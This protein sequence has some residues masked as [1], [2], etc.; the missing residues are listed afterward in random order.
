MGVTSWFRGLFGQKRQGTG[1]E[2]SRWSSAPVRRGTAQLIF[3][4]KELPWLNTIVDT[5]SDGVADLQWKVYRPVSSGGALC[6]DFSLRFGNSKQRRE[7]LKA[8]LDAGEAV[9]VNNH[10]LLRLISDPNDY[11][12][13]RQV[14]KLVQT[15]LDLV[16]EAFLVLDLQGKLPVGYWPLPPHAVTLLPD[17]TLPPADQ[18][19]TVTFG[20]AS[21][22]VPA[23]QIVHLRHPDPDDPMGRGVGKGFT[24]GDELDTD[25]Y[26]AQFM[27]NFFFNNAMPAGV[28]SIEGAPP[29]FSTT[30]QAQEFRESL[31]REYG[32]SK[33]AGKVMLTG[34][35]VSV[36]RLDTDF[37]KMDLNSLRKGLRDFTRMNW[38]IPPEIVGDLTSSSKTAAWAAHDNLAKQAIVPRGEFLRSEFQMR[39][40]PFFG[41]E[42]DIIDYGSPCPEDQEFELRVMGTFPSSFT[43]NEARTLAGK[44]PDPA[45]KGYLSPLPGQDPSAGTKPTP[46]A[47]QGSQA[48]TSEEQQQPSNQKNDPPWAA[49]PIT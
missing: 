35:K 49:E 25:E 17:Y 38:R 7:R 12:T 31:K 23:S 39:F 47:S 15:Y 43:H 34:G 2:V 11:L 1:F 14:Q 22:R 19:Y 33:N 24:L 6:K 29:N 30:P 26:A 36:A 8:M 16:G 42:G 40:M 41:V 21:R 46:D 4:Y 45:L 18:F 13:G 9:E 48:D 5:V 10:P 32:G 44:R 3:A 27:K 37:Q 28:I 20:R